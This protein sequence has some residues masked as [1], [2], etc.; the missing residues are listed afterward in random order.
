MNISRLLAGKTGNVR[1]TRNFILFSIG[2]LISIF[3]T[4]IYTFALGLH[5]LKLTGSGLSFATALALVI[6][7]MVLIN[8]FAGV[9]ADRLNKKVLVVVM[10]LANGILL[11]AVYLLSLVYGLGIPLIYAAT[12][13]LTVFTTFFGV[14]MEA[15]KPN[16]VTQSM[17]MNINSMSKII[18]SVSAILGPMVGG[19]IF[20]LI[21]IRLFIVINGISFIFSAA[22]EMFID[23][24]LN[25]K[26]KDEY[27]TGSKVDF[28]K[29]IKEGFQYL[30]ERKEIKSLFVIL[31]A[32]NFVIGFSI[33]VPLPFI[34]NNVLKL[35]SKEFGIIQ[36]AFPVGVIAGAL[37]VEKACK[38]IAYYRL[39]RVLNCI[40]SLCM[41][42][43]ALPVM[44]VGFELSY[45]G[46]LVYY[47]AVM[48][49]FGIIISFIDIPISYTMQ[50]IIPE[51]YRG[52]VL[53]IGVSIGKTMLPAAL[54]LSGCL[55]NVIPVYVMPILGGI[56]LFLLSM[57][58]LGGNSNKF[59]WDADMPERYETLAE[60]NDGELCRIEEYMLQ[61]NIVCNSVFFRSYDIK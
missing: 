49:I 26:E 59:L 47:S 24:K 3:G 55:L 42:L 52:R 37:L 19:I 25:C 45:A 28:L 13:L 33:N 4:S 32:L 39:L 46:Y 57:S 61:H 30:I 36:G 10:D 50:S 21:D 44:P 2:K 43:I 17:L 29:D 41:L 27:N 12:F 16:V 40:M 5:V 11:I 60:A 23:F 18:D 15:A 51:E 53:S 6:I 9:A 35:S 56:L 1:A 58:A 20:A 7:P 34:I 14:A 38:K 31:I 48:I 22:L 54:I 8:P